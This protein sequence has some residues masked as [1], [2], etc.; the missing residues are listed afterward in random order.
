MA[1]S[2]LIHYFGIPEE[3]PYALDM[4][5]FLRKHLTLQAGTTL[6]RRR[7]LQAAGRYLA[8]HRPLAERYVTHTYEVG[9]I[10]ACALR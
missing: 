5:K 3:H 10:Q 4:W 9:D 6:E 8:A 1:P 2:G 7:H